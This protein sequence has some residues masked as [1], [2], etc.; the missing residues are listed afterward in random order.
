[1]APLVPSCGSAALPLLLLSNVPQ[2]DEAPA[3]LFYFVVVVFY[4]LCLKST[5]MV[6]VWELMGK[7]A[8]NVYILCVCVYPELSISIG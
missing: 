6:S 1:M 4:E 3:F 5:F 8:R 2:D 7:S